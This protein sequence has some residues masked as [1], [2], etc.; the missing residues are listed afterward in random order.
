MT[1]YTPAHHRGQKL[2]PAAA[3]HLVGRF[4]Y[5]LTPALARQA[6][7][8]G[9][10]RRWFDQQLDP[11]SIADGHSESLRSWW[12]SLS[13]SA[14]EIWHRQR[15]DVEGGWEVMADYQRWVLLRRI[16]SRRQ[17]LEV[18]TELWENHFNV[19]VYGDAAWFWRTQ[20]GDT[21]RARALGR[22]DDLLHAVTTHPAML[23]NLDN[24]SSSARHPNEN[25]GREL[26]ELHTVGR[27][28]Y[29]EDDVKGSAR[30]L[31]GWSVDMWNT[32]DAV[33]RPRWHWTG[34]VQVM[35]FTHPNGDA[36]G[37]HVTKQ[38]LTHLAHHP[39]TARRV[40]RKLAVKF[41]R[42]DPS[43]E[44]VDMLAQVYLDHD[45]EIRPV[46]RAL[47]RSTEFTRSVGA[48]VRDPGE[49]VVATY[50][51][52]DVRVERPPSGRAGQS[53]A[54]DQI[55]WQADAIGTKPFDWP[56]PDGQPIDNAA[57]ASPS[58]ML[59]S[60]S[61]H[62]DMAGTWWPKTGATYHSPAWWVPGY[63]VR[64]DLLVD[65][66]SQRILHRRSTAQLLQACCEAVDVQPHERITRDHGLVRWNFYRL[67]TTFLDS[68]AFLTR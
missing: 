20:F 1:T 30:I 42:D 32:F 18:V 58:R 50:R 62:V 65:H 49:D 17:V 14:T 53:W 64:F 52:L 55:L 37:R 61:V 44:L 27:G 10:A 7:A 19:P 66:L 63:P 25:L 9:G 40:A 36:D 68:P 28:E 15:D 12:P 26:L 48:K 2:L 5:G 23:I 46:L 67:L 60:M 38:Y 11:D 59:A 3:R 47:V 13:R 6:R 33:Y 16:H 39:A 24:V 35:D 57:W 29:G 21:I 56:R 34:P 51:A 31:T 41:V 22:F 43:D 54:A 8:A 4:S 45:T